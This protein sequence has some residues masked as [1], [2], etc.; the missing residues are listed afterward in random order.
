M[1]ISQNLA[2]LTSNFVIFIYFFQKIQ[3]LFHFEMFLGVKAYISM[4]IK[5]CNSDVFYV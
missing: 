1:L 4:F 2:K 5:H 3:I